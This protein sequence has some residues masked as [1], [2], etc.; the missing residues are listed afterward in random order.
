MVTWRC[1]HGK[2]GEGGRRKYYRGVTGW[3]GRETNGSENDSAGDNGN[4]GK[5][6]ENVHHVGW[7]GDKTG[8]K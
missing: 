8:D 5:T 3:N 6:N 2:E 1:S 4:G 7:G